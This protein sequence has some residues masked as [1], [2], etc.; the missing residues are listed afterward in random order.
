MNSNET[1]E[2]RDRAD[3]LTRAIEADFKLP[4][5]APSAHGLTY[6]LQCAV[7]VSRRTLKLLADVERVRHRHRPVSKELDYTDSLV[8]PEE[9]E[10]TEVQVCAEC[11]GLREEANGMASPVLWPCSTIRDLDGDTETRDEAA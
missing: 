4:W 1:H 3:A 2:L 5:D 7:G 6:W 11:D 9:D 8:E 10:P